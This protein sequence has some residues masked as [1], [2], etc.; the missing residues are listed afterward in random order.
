MQNPSLW[1][2]VCVIGCG[3][4][5]NE[6]IVE[7][8]KDPRAYENQQRHFHGRFLIDLRNQIG[9]RDIDSDSGRQRQARAYMMAEEGHG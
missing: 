9:G 6:T 2:P 5:A 1:A 3:I 4:R 7:Q 8:E